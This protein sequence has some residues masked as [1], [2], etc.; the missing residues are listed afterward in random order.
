MHV[1]VAVVGGTLSYHDMAKEVDD[2]HSDAFQRRSLG[3]KIKLETIGENKPSNL[4]GG[5]SA[6]VKKKSMN[7][8]SQRV[9]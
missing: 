2:R 6:A 3:K 7:C 8:N 9:Y 4:R 5:Q 1:L